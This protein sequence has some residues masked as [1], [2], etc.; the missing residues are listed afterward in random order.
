MIRRPPRSTRTATL[1]PYP[2][3]FRSTRAAL[4]QFANGGAIVNIGAGAADRA[5][6][7]M[8]AYAASKAGV[9]RLTEALAAEL[10]DRRI[11]VNAV[12]PSVIDTPAN[13]ADIDR[14]STRLN[15][16]H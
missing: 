11:R 6:A 14:K 12:L 10:R 2:T 1:L 7:G 13:R 4:P 16:S 15:S 8:G 5:A 9:A 3:L